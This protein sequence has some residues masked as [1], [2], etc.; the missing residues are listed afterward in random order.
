MNDLRTEGSPMV[1]L[2][3]LKGPPAHATG[4]ATVELFRERPEPAAKQKGGA[5]SRSTYLFR[6][7]V[8][9]ARLQSHGCA[10]H[11]GRQAVDRG[12]EGLRRLDSGGCAVFEL[13]MQPG[14]AP[15]LPQHQNPEKYARNGR[16]TEHPPRSRL[17]DTPPA[18]YHAAK[19]P[20][21]T[22]SAVTTD[23]PADP[24]LTPNQLWNLRIFQSALWFRRTG[25][26]GPSASWRLIE[27]S[28]YMIA[29]GHM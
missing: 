24:P 8:A 2:F 15:Y 10:E 11:R 19:T 7:G 16:T 29:G 23:V 3:R 22:K 27:R 21:P 26:L 9:C 4:A 14:D 28:S 1:G 13:F 6:H 17:A 20:L 18:R 12:D 5:P 25:T